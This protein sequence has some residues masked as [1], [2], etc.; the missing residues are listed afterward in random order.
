ML[1]LVKRTREAALVFLILFSLFIAIYASEYEFAST[2][3]ACLIL[4]YPRHAR[5][6]LP[7]AFFVYRCLAAATKSLT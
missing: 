6:A 4:F 2:N 1:V 7:L 5:W 3:M